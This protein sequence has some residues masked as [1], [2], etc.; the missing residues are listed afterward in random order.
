MAASADRDVH[1]RARY[2]HP[3][4]NDQPIRAAATVYLYTML[5]THADG[6]V[7]PADGTLNFAGVLTKR[8]PGHGSTAPTA[9]GDRRGVLT[10]D[11]EFWFKNSAS[12]AI[13]AAHLN[14]EVFIEADD[15]VANTGTVKAGRARRLETING[16]SGVW[17]DITGYC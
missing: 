4:T 16:V 11:G 17:V 6:N 3:A 5:G 8:F 10:L 2:Q 7:V 14:D 1:Y 12:N 15:I 9:S 13:A